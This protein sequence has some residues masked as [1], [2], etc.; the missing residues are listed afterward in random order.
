MTASA[1]PAAFIRLLRSAG[2]RAFASNVDFC[3]AEDKDE[4]AE[5]MEEVRGMIRGVGRSPGADR[6]ELTEEEAERSGSG[7]PGGLEIFVS[8][9]LAAMSADPMP[10]ISCG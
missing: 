10:V 9:G 3:E 2:L 7:A 8:P 4:I 5:S 6:T 1:D